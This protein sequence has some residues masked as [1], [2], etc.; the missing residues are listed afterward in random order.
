MEPVN[1]KTRVRGIVLLSEMDVNQ[2]VRRGLETAVEMQCACMC[3]CMVLYRDM[4][5]CCICTSE[6]SSASHLPCE[7]S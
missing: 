5:V 3:G 4:I 7:E 1:S 6:G 2:M